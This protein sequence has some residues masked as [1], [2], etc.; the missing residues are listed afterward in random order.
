MNIS[1]CLTLLFLLFV[2]NFAV[3]QRGNPATAD[4]VSLQGQFDEM[5][6]VSSKYQIY[7]TVRRTFLDAFMANVQDSISGYTE[8]ISRLENRISEQDAKIAEQ[9]TAIEDR[10]GQI[11]VLTEEKDSI[12]LLGMPLSKGAYSL[13]LWSAIIALLAM[14]LL[15]LA[16]M[17]L[18]VGSARQA[19]Q[20]FLQVNEDLEKSRK[21]R[22]EVEQKLRRQLQDEIN[23]RN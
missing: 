8:E 11:G 18:A 19:Q 5:L 2:A 7:K 22:L 13:I 21:T 17:R 1:R 23:K 12:S 6:R 4:T 14:L 9:A 15:A 20:D 16:R 3:A 10:Q